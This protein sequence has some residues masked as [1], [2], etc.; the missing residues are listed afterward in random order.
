MR[1]GLPDLVL[2][3]HEVLAQQRNVHG[4]PDGVEI[5]QRAAEAALL[6]QDADHGGPAVGV[7]CGEG[8]GIGDVRELALGRAAALDLGN[9]LELVPGARGPAEGGPGVTGG[10]R[11]GGTLLQL[12]ERNQ[13][14]A[15]LHI[16]PDTGID[17]VENAHAQWPEFFSLLP[18]TP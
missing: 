2:V 16:L 9:H 10:R 11:R 5:G 13:T 17:V 1:P 7:L 14:L 15:R 8:R 3:N 4:G 6:G 18:P 12:R